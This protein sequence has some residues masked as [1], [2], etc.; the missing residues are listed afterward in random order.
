MLEGLGEKR[1]RTLSDNF[2]RFLFAR[3]KKKKGKETSLNVFK[4]RGG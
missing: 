2:V 4:C 3:L 1:G